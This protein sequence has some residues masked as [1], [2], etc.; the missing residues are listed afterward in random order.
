[1]NH[2]LKRLSLVTGSRGQDGSYLRELIGIDRSIGIINPQTK[3]ETTKKVPGEL[4]IDLSDYKA[5]LEILTRFQPDTIFHLAASHG[6]SGQMTYSSQDKEL[7]HKVHVLGTQNL[8]RASLELKLDTNVV[9]AGSKR[10]FG[11]PSYDLVADEQTPPNPIDFYGETKLMA[12]DLVREFRKNHGVAASFLILFNH[13]SP[14]RP[15]G[16]LSQ[17][18][19]S[20]LAQ[21]L[22]GTS[23]Q[24]KVNNANARAD[25]SDARDVVKFMHEIGDKKICEDFVV[26]SG[27]CLSVMEL[28]NG[29]CKELGMDTPRVSSI[30]PEAQTQSIFCLSANQERLRESGAWD[31]KRI[32]EGTL[33]EMVTIKTIGT[34]KPK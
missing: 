25:W 1:M 29:A 24:V 31:P 19:S 11:E 21:I 9:L 32:I 15:E 28:I 12:W 34:L 3:K 27:R 18:L 30:V 6:P 8:L 17:S 33:A 7:M 10:I 13:E 20:Q 22:S 4:S 5:V 23:D 16:Y 2:S 26:G 14:R